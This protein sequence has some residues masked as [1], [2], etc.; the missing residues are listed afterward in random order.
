MPPT[1][2]A[3]GAVEPRPT[4]WER[5]RPALGHNTTTPSPHCAAR[6]LCRLSVDTSRG[7]KK[8][9]ARHGIRTQ[10]LQSFEDRTVDLSRC[11]CGRASAGNVGNAPCVGPQHNHDKSATRGARAPRAIGRYSTWQKK[12]GPRATGF[13]REVYNLV[14]DR[15]ADLS[16][17]WCGRASADGM[18]RSAPLRW[19]TTQPFQ[20]RTARH[21]CWA[22][23]RYSTGRKARGPRA[24]G[25]DDGDYKYSKP[26]RRPVAVL[27]RSSL[28]RRHGEERAPRW[29]TTQPRQ[30][31]IVRRAYLSTPWAVG[32]YSAG[33]KERGP[34]TTVSKYGDHIVENESPTRHGVGAVEPRPTAWVGAPQ[35]NH[36]KPALRGVCAPWAVGR[37]STWRKA[38]GPRST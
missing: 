23:G 4:A 10:C 6:A 34:R 25:L 17:C 38:R 5:A 21:V 27:V 24:M 1:C 37:H 36:P 28:G 33:Q 32:R 14:E 19:A 18:G 30:A 31:R 35:R 9:T 29:A 16:W 7:K 3:L 26:C 11:W 12:R 22:V 8:R 13:E 20:A 15:V 2:R